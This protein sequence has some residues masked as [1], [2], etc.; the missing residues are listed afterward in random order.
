MIDVVEDD[1]QAK[2]GRNSCGF[3]QIDNVEREF[4]DVRIFVCVFELKKPDEVRE[5][6]IS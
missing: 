5:E 3:L 2:Y 1:Y 4:R 6:R